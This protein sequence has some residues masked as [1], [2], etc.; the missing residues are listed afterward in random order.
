MSLLYNGST[1]QTQ[2]DAA[3]LSRMACRENK[4]KVGELFSVIQLDANKV[5]EEETL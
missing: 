5:E 2:N 3:L 1:H 4:K